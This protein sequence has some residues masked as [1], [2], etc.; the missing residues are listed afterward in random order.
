[1]PA[2]VGN[3]ALLFGPDDVFAMAAAI[4]SLWQDPD[5][6][7]TLGR[8]GAERLREFSLNR[9][10]QHVRALYRQIAGQLTERDREILAAPPPI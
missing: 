7:E 1:L 3:A 8:R 6:R 2:Q 9:M 4:R 5:L 10:G